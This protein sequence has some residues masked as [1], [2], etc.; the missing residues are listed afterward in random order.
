MH[1]Y[2]VVVDWYIERHLQISLS[3][4]L[5]LSLII[6]RIFKVIVV[7]KAIEF[8]TNSHIYLIISVKITDQQC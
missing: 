8:L 7:I 4:L 5:Y 1:T 3:K 2:V 6:L